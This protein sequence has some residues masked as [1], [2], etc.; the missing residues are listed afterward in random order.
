MAVP[1]GYQADQSV[2]VLDIGGDPGQQRV[3]PRAPT[4]LRITK[5]ISASAATTGGRLSS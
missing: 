3:Y 4:R 2:C 1:N 5:L